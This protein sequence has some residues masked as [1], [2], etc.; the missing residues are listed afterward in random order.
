MGS[1]VQNRAMDSNVMY[2]RFFPLIPKTMMKKIRR[3]KKNQ[4]HP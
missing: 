4:C 1:I 2:G 3:I